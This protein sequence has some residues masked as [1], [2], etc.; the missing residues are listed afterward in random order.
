METVEPILSIAGGITAMA[1]DSQTS[2]RLA[3]GTGRVVDG[4][5]GLENILIY[6]VGQ[7]ALAVTLP[8]GQRDVDT[9]SFRQVS[10][11][12][13]ISLSPRARWRMIVGCRLLLLPGGP[14]RPKRGLG[15]SIQAEDP[16][17]GLI[18]SLVPLPE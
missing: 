11:S 10:Q 5:H 1:L 12:I 4:L 14:A 9:V 16:L 13:H 8:A 17:T 3:V 15:W 6:D 18:G 2:S 7:R